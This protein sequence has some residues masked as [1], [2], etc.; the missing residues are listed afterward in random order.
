MRPHDIDLR[1]TNERKQR[2]ILCLLLLCLLLLCFKSFLYTILG[3]L[4]IIKIRSIL[5]NCP[6]IK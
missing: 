6:Y 4:G 1:F 2:S 5:K 3:L